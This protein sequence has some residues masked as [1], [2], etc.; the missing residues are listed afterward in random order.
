MGERTAAGVFSSRGGPGEGVLS[1]L[2]FLCSYRRERDA[3]ATAGETPALRGC[4]RHGLDVCYST[5]FSGTLCKER[6][7]KGSDQATHNFG[8]RC[9]KMAGSR[10][11]RDKFP[12]RYS[13]NH[14]QLL[15]PSICHFVPCTFLLTRP[16][17]YGSLSWLSQESGGKRRREGKA[18][19]TST[20]QGEKRGNGEKDTKIEGTNSAIYGK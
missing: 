3:P 14:S 4:R 15:T 16:P 20:R 7:C 11:D 19:G 17:P 10:Y 9:S 13:V 2:L 12:R 1:Q 18:K 6:N 5:P 8:L